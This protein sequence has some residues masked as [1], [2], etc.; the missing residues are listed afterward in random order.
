MGKERGRKVEE[1]KV[2]KLKRGNKL[3]FISLPMHNTH[4]NRQISTRSLF[5]SFPL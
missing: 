3:K 5:F 1:A 4:V 2:K